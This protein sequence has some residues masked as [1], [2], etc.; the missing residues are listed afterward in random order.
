MLGVAGESLFPNMGPR[1]STALPSFSGSWQAD[2]AITQKVRR[3]SRHI[4][5]KKAMS[6]KWGQKNGSSLPR[7]IRG[8]GV[9]YISDQDI[10]DILFERNR[11]LSFAQPYTRAFA[12]S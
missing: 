4:F 3:G 1:R 10:S 5:N 6:E 2:F 11:K 8:G 7:F 9:Y 12:G